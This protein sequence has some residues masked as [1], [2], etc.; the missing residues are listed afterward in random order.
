MFGQMPILE[1]LQRH[2]QVARGN[3]H[4]PGHRQGAVLPAAFAT[5][6]GHAAKL[7]L[8]ELPGLDNLMAP[9]ECIL[10]SEKLA[11]SHYGSDRCF[12]TVNGSSAGIMAALVTVLQPGDTVLFVNPF[13]LSAWN[14]LVHSGADALCLPFH[15]SDEGRQSA[16]DAVEVREKLRQHHNIKAVFLTSPT[17][18]GDTADVAAIAN[19]VHDFGLPLIVDEAHGAHFG[20]VP[21]FPLH[22]IALG[23]DIVVQSTHKMLPALTQTAWIHIQGNRVSR[24]RFAAVLNSFQTSSPSY[25]L[26]ASLDA[27]QAWLRSEGRAAAE[28]TVWRLRKYGLLEE[29]AGGWTGLEVKPVTRDGL[30]HWIPADRE[31]SRL[32][33]DM[34]AKHGIFVEYADGTGVLSVLGLDIEERV[35]SEYTRIVHDWHLKRDFLPQSRRD[36]RHQGIADLNALAAAA[37]RTFA[38]RPRDADRNHGRLVLLERSVGTVSAAPIVPYPPG[39]P[40]VYPGQELSQAAVEVLSRWFASGEKIQGISAS[41]EIEVMA[42]S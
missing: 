23:A 7:D 25:L 42:E 11:A 5:W 29:P 12:Y 2:V 27:A 26:L 38:I 37:P 34:L 8:T 32:L 33:Q 6:M 41:G 17:Y 13:H 18:Q 15:Y 9:E 16:P 28:R 35:L 20:L 40:L 24:R 3:L 14:G 30:K 4:V 19:A 10:E 39:V 1:A 36:K 31:G 22:S 21:E